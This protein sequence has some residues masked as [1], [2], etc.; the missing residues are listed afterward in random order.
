VASPWRLAI[1]GRAQSGAESWRAFAC[2][3]DHRGPGRTPGPPPRSPRGQRGTSTSSPTCRGSFRQPDRLVSASS[4]VLRGMRLGAEAR[5]SITPAARQ[6]VSGRR[7]ASTD[8]G[9]LGRLHHRPTSLDSIEQELRAVRTG[10]SVSVQLHPVLLGTASL[11]AVY[12]TATADT[13]PASGNSI[14]VNSADAPHPATAPIGDRANAARTISLI[15][16]F[17]SC[18]FVVVCDSRKPVLLVLGRTTSRWDVIAWSP[19]QSDGEH[20][21]GRAY[22]GPSNC[23]SRDEP[24]LLLLYLRLGRRADLDE[25]SG[26]ELVYPAF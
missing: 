26:F 15:L 23:R 6:R 19:R 13:P 3:A 17:Y 5:S 11:F 14:F 9:G 10:P 2:S 22:P 21:T 7:R 25:D 24:Q 12:L 8:S 20:A 4:G 16:S 18:S 1:T